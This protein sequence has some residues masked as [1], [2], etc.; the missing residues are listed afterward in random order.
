MFFVVIFVADTENFINRTLNCHKN[1]TELH[2]ILS[3]RR[4]VL[5]LLIFASFFLPTKLWSHPGGHHG[6]EYD[7]AYRL[8]REAEHSLA[9]YGTLAFTTWT[10][11]EAQFLIGLE[12]LKPLHEGGV[13]AQDYASAYICFHLAAA[14]GHE[15]AVDM[16]N[17]VAKKVSSDKI[18]EAFGK[19]QHCDIAGTF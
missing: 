12:L 19:Y 3:M 14:Q 17:F 16:R 8:I 18:E 15:S 7:S 10:S 9:A 4:S 2:L 13:L 11:P 1:G 5:A 6:D